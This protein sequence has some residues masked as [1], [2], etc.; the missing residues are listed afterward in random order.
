[1]TKT[2]RISA[3]QSQ[4]LP[5]GQTT[6]FEMRHGQHLRVG[7]AK[8]SGRGVGDGDA[9]AAGCQ[10]LV[11]RRDQDLRVHFDDGT[12]VVF[13]GFYAV[14]T[15]AESCSVNLPGPDAQG[16]TVDAETPAWR[17]TAQ[18]DLIYAYGEPACLLTMAKDS[19][20]LSSALL[21]LDGVSAHGGAGLNLASM[22]LAGSGLVFLGAW[23]GKGDSSTPAPPPAAPQGGIDPASDTGVVGDGITSDM[24]PTLSGSGA[25][26]GFTITVLMPVTGEVLHV[27]VGADGTWQ[28]TPTQALP[29]GTVGQIRVTLT[30]LEG[31]TSEPTWIPI[32]TISDLLIEGTVTGGPMFDGIAL[33]ARDASGAIIATTEIQ[34][35]GTYS[36]RVDR[37][38]NYRGAITV[39]A[40]DAN[41]DAPNYHDE[42]TGFTKSL[43]T[44]LR[45]I[46]A[47][48][49]DNL[50]AFSVDADGNTRLTVNISFMSELAARQV[51]GT[52]AAATR[53]VDTASIVAANQHVA[54]AFGIGVGLDITTIAPTATNAADFNAADGISDSE[55][56]G[57][58]LAKLSGLDAINGGN[59]AVS[60]EQLSATLVADR[61]NEAGLAL[62]DQGRVQALDALKR[63]ATT[64]SA[65]GDD[66]DTNNTL[67]RQ[68]LGEAVITAQTLNADGSWL[69][70]GTA[71]PGSRVT[72]TL[73]D[74]T[75][76]TVEANG[77]GVFV[78][79]A[80]QP[81]PMSSQ[82]LRV[83]AQDA[84]AQPVAYAPPATPVI[85][86]N[87]GRLVTGLGTP[88]STVSV[89]A[90]ADD[91]LLGTATV[92]ALGHWSL[93]LSGQVLGAD[94]HLRTS[95]IDAN[96]NVSAAD[97]QAVDASGLAMRIVSAADGY[98]N[99]AERQLGLVMEVALP[100][101]AQIGDE[102]SL[103]WVGAN[104]ASFEIGPLALTADNLASGWVKQT[105]SSVDLGGETASADGHYTVLAT[106]VNPISGEQVSAPLQQLVLDTQAP[107]APRIYDSNSLSING[108]AEP[109]STI[110]LRTDDGQLVG[111]VGPVGADGNW[112]F[113][114]TSPVAANTR[115]TAQATDAAG[116]AGALSAPATISATALM[117]TAAVD[118]HGA[119]QGLLGDGAQTDDRSP[120]LTGSLSG[121]LQAGQSLQVWRDGQAVDAE[122]VSNGTAWRMAERDLVPGAYE[123]TIQLLDAN[124][125]SLAASRPFNLKVVDPED[126][127]LAPTV[128]IAEASG[129]LGDTYINASERSSDGGVPLRIM[130]AEMVLGDVVTTR[131]SLPGTTRASF[132]FTSTITQ[133]DINRGFVGQLLPKTVLATEGLYQLSTTVTSA[134]NGVASAPVASSFTVD[135]RQPSLGIGAVALSDDTGVSG[136]DFL[137]GVRE[138]TVTA[139]LTGQPG[140]GDRLMGTVD[141]GLHWQD[142]SDQVQGRE[143]QWSG[144]TLADRGVLAF[145]WVDAAGNAGAIQ[146]RTPYA[147]DAASP[148][149]PGL[150]ASNGVRISGTGEPGATVVVSEQGAQVV[151]TVSVAVDGRWVLS[152]DVPLAHET[153]LVATQTD[154]AGNG[155]SEPAQVT[156]DAGIPWMA[157]TA[158]AS[159]SG[160]G[161]PGDYV[162]VSYSH[163]GET[164]SLPPVQVAANG[165]WQVNPPAEQ[166]P[167][168]GT[169]VTATNV[170]PEPGAPWVQ[171]SSTQQV[172]LTP[173][174]SP[175]L[176]LR[177]SSDSG[178][179]ANDALTQVRN[180]TV[181]GQGEPHSTIQLW[182][183]GRLVATAQVDAQ[184][185]WACTL[186]NSAPLGD[187][188]HA[189]H[190]VAIDA[191][192]NT[193]APS[194]VLALHVKT[195]AP[196]APVWVQVVDD[197]KEASAPGRSLD[198]GALS[199]DATPSL[200]LRAE[201]SSVV[202]IHDEGR[203]LGVAQ[204]IADDAGLF[205]F[206]PAASE[207]LGEGLHRLT[208]TATDAAGNRSAEALPFALQIDTL[209][210]AA[211][212]GLPSNGVRL[213][214]TGE[215]GARVHLRDEQGTDLASAEVGADGQWE[216]RLSTP[217]PDGTLLVASQT[218]AA[219][220]G[221]SAP[222]EVIIQAHLP[223]IDPTRG[224]LISGTGKP[225][226]FIELSF[227][228]GDSVVVLPQV[229]VAADGRW[230]L[231]PMGDE[232][233]EHGIE[234]TARA[235][236]ADRA[237]PVDLGSS[238]TL[239][240]TVAP[241][242]PSLALSRTH[243]TGSSDHD[244]LTAQ[245]RIEWSGTA[246]AGSTV[247]V[248]DANGVVG[249]AKAD[250]DGHWRLQA[251]S[252]VADGEH[253]YW[254]TASDAAGN[255][256]A[257]TAGLSLV[258]DTRA[259]DAPI[260]LTLT[261]SG[262]DIVANALN[263]STSTLAFSATLVPGQA[264]G[265]WA[266]FALDGAVM[267]VDTEITET[268]DHVSLTLG[269]SSPTAQSLQELI[270]SGGVF[271]LQ[272][273]DAAGN[274]V[275]ASGP[276]LLRDVTAPQAPRI[277]GLTADTDTGAS[278]AD[279]TTANRQPW[280]QGQGI[281]GD[282]ITVF[283][284]QGDLL[285]T[286]TVAANGTWQ[287]PLPQ[288]EEAQHTLIAYAQDA[289]GNRS[290]ASNRLHIDVDASA[291]VP[292]IEGL[293]PAT[294]GGLSQSDGI[295]PVTAP[296]LAGRAQAHNGIQIFDGD[297]LLGST[298]AVADGSWQLV[299]PTLSEG[300]HLLVA[301]AS[302]LA[303]NTSEA[304]AASWV[305]IDTLASTAPSAITLTPSGGTV[306][307]NT[308]NS[309]N[310]AMGFAATVVA[311]EATGGRADFYVNGVLMGSDADISA[312]DTQVGVTLSGDTPSAAE[313]QALI[314]AGG[315][316][317]VKLF[318]AAGNAVTGT[319][320]TLLR[321]ITPPAAPTLSRVV[322][323]SDTGSSDSDGISADTTPTLVGSGNPGDWIEL[324]DGDG[325][326]L[327][328]AFVDDNG[329]WVITTSALSDGV[330]AITARA[331]DPAGN[332]GAA[333]SALSVR[334][335]TTGPTAASALTLT[336]SGGT[337]VA[338]TLNSSNTAMDF[339]ATVVA[340]EAAGG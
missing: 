70:Q 103:T 49:V 102:L 162:V 178:F 120:L 48:E 299:L 121:V 108:T 85:E 323:A 127:P 18:G 156:V 131:L 186:G 50:S 63:H 198:A 62:V 254:A 138:Q 6:V 200:W 291:Q 316:V 325:S 69:V 275:S 158:G 211:P 65:G 168:D 157:P 164:L 319:G 261:P 79:Q 228:R 189:L 133:D 82:A 44:Q 313:L 177:S 132:S 199:N 242:T 14:C 304:S 229:Q 234:L 337:V 192:G 332:T 294:D 187:G 123:Y 241:A 59:V 277:M 75:Q 74:E 8:D 124:G 306:V 238:S 137:T 335:D 188:L 81:Q 297:V 249:S 252:P 331:T 33:E 20:H 235:W 220:N 142:I 112:T 89:F 202:Q 197:V 293:T 126:R 221:P 2:I 226:D 24:T 37:S 95:A 298:S 92:D 270:A 280:V 16:V 174:E 39:A 251:A 179:S 71:L 11:T 27:V 312:S 87:N 104:S 239:V 219:G 98:V 248:S 272:V 101:S 222:S 253:T 96:G 330:H 19:P 243:D 287:A 57:L 194:A 84:L 225:G 130:P 285:A 181:E 193:S 269:D 215:P 5:D 218:D 42:V 203:L 90:G 106:L 338:N 305:Y 290:E 100:I 334:I 125:V 310:T 246:E 46:G 25:T 183:S 190:A 231:T 210:P 54:A 236:G 88:G 110:T 119:R 255:T 208:A 328:G 97:Q 105:M 160:T 264:T 311:G 205:V 148:Q 99:A 340:G 26:P 259:P 284:V 279:A 15:S 315:V 29:D 276:E 7:V 184:G 161:R 35:D 73:P 55:R 152:P 292:V 77:Q 326:E 51:L 318:D 201:P 12:E 149:A 266:V 191:A 72:L 247:V 309:S 34:G 94:A 170:G 135:V 180:P 43:N 256:S 258:V 155:P 76:H 141:D 45:G 176:S 122:V 237:N 91:A 129:Q 109:G 214:G 144:V 31:K 278:S 300:E 204:E 322:A 60:L 209:I 78:F 150:E 207:P 9:P 196:A 47:A 166:V 115:I 93:N 38:G 314:A 30:D 10:L 167:S 118:D 303:G 67:N 265:G 282:R 165:R 172:D 41:G 128:W 260:Q 136:Q 321:D 169:P 212:T 233:P 171:G 250:R 281:A 17:E 53:D 244:G 302:D 308:L 288:M 320:P 175:S 273:F 324:L 113:I 56:V 21:G 283:N 224:D 195:Q 333:S 257:P 83:S 146:A 139:R 61:F 154:A 40:I 153:V 206:T 36:M 286:A 245:A 289:V 271:S 274:A 336:P 185:D 151:G 107:A 4:T 117:V 58:A 111:A 339:A 163:A 1:M 114:A 140:L 329:A 301:V 227:A 116:N 262:G 145:R 66:L 213:S 134:T 217:L 64:F 307:V 68:L 240:D 230:T 216:V 268:D 295:T 52:E 80:T 232:V 32:S 147:V 296:T 327:G 86:A 263:G 143:L 3:D 317:T 173:P 22:A 23:S 267:G 159:I 13:A 28:V 223:L 182:D